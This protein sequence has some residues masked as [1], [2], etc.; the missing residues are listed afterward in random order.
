MK[1]LFLY[2]LGGC[3]DVDECVDAPCGENS[4][5]RNIDGSFECDC[6]RDFHRN[7]HGD[8]IKTK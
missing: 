1:H 4:I 7:A 2:I 3:T 6:L 8:C 5:C